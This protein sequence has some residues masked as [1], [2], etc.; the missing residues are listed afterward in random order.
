MTASDSVASEHPDDSKSETAAKERPELFQVSK[1]ERRLLSWINIV[2][3]VVF[4]VVGLPIWWRTTSVYRAWLP[5]ADI[6]ALQTRRLIV[7][8]YV[9]V[10]S[11]DP[12]SSSNALSTLEVELWPALAKDAAGSDRVQVRY[13]V[14]KE[15]RN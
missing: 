11:C 6:E 13:Q 1:Q 14:R 9:E 10:I 2:Y 15:D 8:Q 12:W 5:H 7:M 4:V 3:A